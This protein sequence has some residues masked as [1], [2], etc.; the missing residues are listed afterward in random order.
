MQRNLDMAM[1]CRP[2]SFR[3]RICL[4]SSMPPPSWSAGNA[5]RRSAAST[6]MRPAA[7]HLGDTA[8]GTPVDI[9]RA[10]AEADFRICLGNIEF[11]YFAG[12]SG[13]APKDVNLYQ[14]QKALDNAKHAVKDGGTIILIGACREGWA[15]R[16]FLT[17]CSPRRPRIP[18]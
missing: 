18:W 6:P 5:M 15:A 8:H 3:R 12:Y 7:S 2:W 16:P 14:T 9:T 4:A 10:V 11:H 17:G 1:A 13:G